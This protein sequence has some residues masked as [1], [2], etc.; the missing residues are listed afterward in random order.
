MLG[1]LYRYM[2]EADPAHFQPM[3]SNWGLVDPLERRIR[4]KREKRARLGE[5]AGQDFKTWMEAEGLTGRP[6]DGPAGPGVPAAELP[7]VV[8]EP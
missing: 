7:A 1:A 3:N 4:N 6:V 8:A 2:R 5:R